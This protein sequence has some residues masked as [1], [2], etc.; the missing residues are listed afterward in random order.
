MEKLYLQFVSSMLRKIQYNVIIPLEFD[1]KIEKIFFS[2]DPI[3][4]SFMTS[5][6]VNGY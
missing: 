3:H 6:V 5:D 2:H 4:Q 1:D